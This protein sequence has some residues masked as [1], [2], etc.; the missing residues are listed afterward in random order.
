METFEKSFHELEK[1]ITGLDK[2]TQ[3]TD[4]R[5]IYEEVAALAKEYHEAAEKAVED[6]K[7]LQELIEKE[8][9]KT[10]DEADAIL[11]R[12]HET[13]SKEE[14]ALHN[15]LSSTIITTEIT[16]LVVAIVG[17]A[18]GVVIS[19]LIA[20]GIAKPVIMM[21]D[22]MKALGEG[23][24]PSRSRPRQS[25]RNRRNG[26]V[27]PGLQGRPDRGRAPAR[28]AGGRAGAADRARQEA[29]CDGCR[30]RQEIGEVV[31]SVSAAATELQSTAKSLSAT[32]EETSQQ[33]NAVAAA[34]EQM[35]QNV[36][37]VAVRDR[38]ADRLDPRDRQPGDGIHPH[39]RRRRHPGRGHQR[40]GEGPGRGGA[41]DRQG[42]DADQ[43]DRQPDQPA[44][45]QRHHRGGARGRGRQGL[46]RGAPARSKTWRPRP[47]R[48]PRRSPARSQAIQE[49]TENLGPGHPGDRRDRQPRSNE[50]S[51]AIASAVE[52]QGAA[53]L[54]ISRNVQEASTGTGGSVVEYRRRDPGLAADQRRIDPGAGLRH[55]NWPG[56]ANG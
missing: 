2:A 42:G 23:N 14:E 56:T 11:D 48:R 16:I 52:E 10:G 1:A 21:T 7:E 30:V 4:M 19:L 31:G 53:T 29:G 49:S 46:C 24:G 36:Q 55:R 6:H 34:S 54:E 12:L 43:R 9:A 45:P 50:I 22:V 15:D 25:R 32:A 41:E 44:G 37:T 47:P 18:L 3:G 33:S 38:G 26:E 40:Q 13:I 20:S 5:P 17:F 8:M 39:R 28:R 35:T 51:T 27:G